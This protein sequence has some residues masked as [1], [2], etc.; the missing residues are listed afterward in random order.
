MTSG[1]D[2][3]YAAKPGNLEFENRI[4]K[5]S[6]NGLL[7]LLQ[8]DSSAWDSTPFHDKWYLGHHSDSDDQ[9][10]LPECVKWI[11]ERPLEKDLDLAE[12]NPGF[13]DFP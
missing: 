12:S 6:P 10:P 11:V 1:F 7:E 9:E 3:E 8:R 2:F 13:N 5:F 4:S